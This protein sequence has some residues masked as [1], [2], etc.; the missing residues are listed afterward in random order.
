MRNRFFASGLFD[1]TEPI[2]D[3]DGYCVISACVRDGDHWLQVQVDTG[4]RASALRPRRRSTS[5]TTSRCS[6]RG[7]RRANGWTRQVK[8]HVSGLIGTCFSMSANG[9]PA[10]FDRSA[11]LSRF[12]AGAAEVLAAHERIAETE[13]R[14]APKPLPDGGYTGPGIEPQSACFEL[15]LEEARTLADASLAPSGGGTHDDGIELGFAHAWFFP[16][17]PD[18]WPFDVFGD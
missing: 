4:G 13:R 6:S 2:S 1:S 3:I 7:C 15:P 11:L 12:P 10:A 5:T 14:L 9:V 8:P 18:K 17:L 16:L